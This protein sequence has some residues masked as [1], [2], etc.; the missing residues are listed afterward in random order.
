MARIF[1]S[2]IIR[3]FK[4][5]FATKGNDNP[6]ETYEQIM[7]TVEIY[8]IEDVYATAINNNLGSALIYTTPTDRDFYLTFASASTQKDAGSTTTRTYIYAQINGVTACILCGNGFLASTAGQGSA[9]TRSRGIKIDR[10][11]SI[12]VGHDTASANCATYGVI[13]G[14]TQNTTEANP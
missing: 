1:N 6:E 14:Y 13:R 5:K 3:D 10:G 7:P 2:N 4:R 12:Y 9:S 11:T 8:P